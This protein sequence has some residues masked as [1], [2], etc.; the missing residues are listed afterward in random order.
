[1]FQNSCFFSFGGSQ[2]S[3]QVFQ[4]KIS[5]R[6]LL[7][8]CIPAINLEVKYWRLQFRIISK[9]IEAITIF[10]RENEQ[11]NQNYR[12][13]TSKWVMACF[14]FTKKCFIDT[15][16]ACVV[17]FHSWCF[18]KNNYDNKI[19]SRV[20]YGYKTH[21]RTRRAN[22][23]KCRIEHDFGGENFRFM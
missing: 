1:M 21:T 20:E 9:L 17:L 4:E 22:F 8:V 12:G 13:W 19:I 23:K 10:Q 18:N 2:S 14:S 5:A 6:I 11:P 16:S 7:A 15:L 3:Y